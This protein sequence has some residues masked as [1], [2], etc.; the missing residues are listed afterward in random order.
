VT[1]PNRSTTRPVERGR[2]DDR[3]D[4]QE[5]IHQAIEVLRAKHQVRETSAFTILIQASVDA[6]M[7]VRDT[8]SRIVADAHAAGRMADR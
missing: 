1:Q 4:A 5:A 2:A 8:A 7:N 3:A 6:H